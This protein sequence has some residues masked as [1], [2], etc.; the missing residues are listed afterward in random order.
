MTFRNPGGGGGGGEE[1][2]MRLI[3]I[4]FQRNRKFEL[5]MEVREL[6]YQLGQQGYKA[7]TDKNV[8]LSTMFKETL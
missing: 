7:L 8:L 2:N 3:S 1:G 4:L 5:R 6:S